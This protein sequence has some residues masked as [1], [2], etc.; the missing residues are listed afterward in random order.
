VTTVNIGIRRV[1][2]QLEHFRSGSIP[3]MLIGTPETWNPDQIEAMQQ[4]WDEMHQGNLRANSGLS[5]IP[6]G[7]DVHDLKSESII[8]NEF[9]EWL[10]R[11]VFFAFSISP[12]A[13]IRDMNRATAETAMEQSKAEGLAPLLSWSKDL[14]DELIQVHLGARGY[15]FRWDFSALENSKDKIARV[16]ALKTAGIISTEM[17]QEIAGIEKHEVQAAP[18]KE[19]PVEKMAKAD[20]TDPDM[21]PEELALAE[22]V[23]PFLDS[24]AE[25]AVLLA[26]GAIE[27]GKPLTG[28]LMTN[29]DRKRFVNAMLPTIKANALAGVSKGAS[30]LAGVEGL[31]N[32]LDV[33]APAAMWARERS[34]WMV[35]MKWVNE[36]LM[37]NPNS[38]YQID[39]VMRD[40]LRSQVSHAIET[41]MTSVKL[42]EAIRSHNAFSWSRANNIARTE[43]AEA[44]EEGQAVYYRASKVVESKKWST[45]GGDTCPRCVGNSDAGAIPLTASFPSGH[46]HPPAHGHCR[47]STVP[48]VKEGL[49]V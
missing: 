29:R 3:Q 19:K 20:E 37:P 16:V 25:K 35:G 15:S 47:C 38:F 48:V 10:A 24:S 33:E 18:V 5:F 41:G 43:I 45:S 30:Q 1:T 4:L 28:D 21:T 2:Q 34:A 23:K 13:L 27:K 12:S 6:G 8:K 49:L 11:I 14:I 40:A 39:D 32:P 44:M 9:D 36:V 26:K 22:K 42:A 31:P 46:L 17:A 7:T